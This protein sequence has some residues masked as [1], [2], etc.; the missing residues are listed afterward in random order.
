MSAGSATL[1]ILRID[2]DL[3]WGE[4]A[5]IFAEAGEP[6]EP[7]TLTKR[8]QRLRDRLAQMAK[9]RGLLD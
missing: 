6:I 1:L 5:E 8:F 7:N 2:Q 4:I 3:S 9:E